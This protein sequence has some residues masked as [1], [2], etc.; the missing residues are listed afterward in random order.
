MGIRISIIAGVIEGKAYLTELL[1]WMMF[2]HDATKSSERDDQ[3][4]L[5]G[6]SR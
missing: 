3:E 1:N 6:P 4:R 5:L 2:V